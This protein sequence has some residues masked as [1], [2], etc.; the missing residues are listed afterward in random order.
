M[1]PLM[2]QDVKASE[3]D[4]LDQMGRQGIAW[5]L[6][7]DVMGQHGTHYTPATIYRRY[8]TMYEK[9]IRQWNTLTVDIRRKA[10]QFRESGDLLALFALLGAAHGIVLAPLVSN[11]EKDARQYA[12]KEL[13]VFT[14]LFLSEQPTTQP[15]DPSKSDMPL[16]NPPIPF[17]QVQWKPGTLE[18]KI[19]KVSNSAAR[20][21]PILIVTP[22]FW[23]SVGG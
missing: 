8:K 1:K 19:T 21:K 10:D 6:H 13:E 4:L 7:P 17:D 15:Y 16:S 5:I 9:D 11:R 12:L 20:S 14:R 22:H 18:S 3:M 2:F 23:P